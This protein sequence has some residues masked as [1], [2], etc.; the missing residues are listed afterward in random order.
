MMNEVDTDETIRLYQNSPPPNYSVSPHNYSNVPVTQNIQTTPNNI[1]PLPNPNHNIHNQT[2]CTICLSALSNEQTRQTTCGHMFHKNCIERWM[3]YS[4]MCP[5]CRHIVVDDIQPI[6]I[7]D[8]PE[9]PNANDQFIDYLPYRFVCGRL[10]CCYYQIPPSFLLSLQLIGII[11]IGFILINS[12]LSWGGT[13]YDYI[14]IITSS[15]MFIFLLVLHILL[16][17]NLRIQNCRVVSIHIGNENE[18]V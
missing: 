13:V 8:L 3:L 18:I 10:R 4:T 11:F 15:L 1:A 9:Y 16:R 17:Y 14:T 5:V 12:A 2:E 7:N 6:V